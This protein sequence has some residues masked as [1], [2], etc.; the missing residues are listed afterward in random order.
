LVFVVIDV[1]VAFASAAFIIVSRTSHALAAYVV[2]A[3]TAV[4]LSAEY[5]PHAGVA[6]ASLGLAIV[7]KLVVAPL[8]VVF[9]MR[10]HAAAKDLRSSLA[11][12][13]RIAL[14]IALAALAASAASMPALRSL[15]MSR[16]IV[17]AVLCGATMIVV[18][19]N[20][21]AGVIGLLAL[22]GAVTLAGAEFAPSVPHLLDLF[23]AFDALVVTVIAV[24]ILRDLHRHY[25]MLDVR[26][27]RKLRG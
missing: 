24:T 8:A 20:L 23:A 25:P 2:L 19:R 10:R 27:L 12:P 26:S 13:A 22:D 21:M 6:L 16:E 14:A 11:L 17:F 9:L 4:I 18:H 7:L 3:A 15:T 1:I 5:M